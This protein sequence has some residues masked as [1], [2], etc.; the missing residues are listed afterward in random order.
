MKRHSFWAALLCAGLLGCTELSSG[1]SE[2]PSFDPT[3]TW[4]T[5][6]LP[7]T[8]VDVVLYLDIQGEEQ[9]ESSFV[10]GQWQSGGDP[11]FA[12]GSTGG[13][14]GT[15][16]GS[17]ITLFLKQETLGM[18]TQVRADLDGFVGAAPPATLSGLYT[19]LQNDNFPECV[20]QQSSVLLYCAEG[21]GNPCGN[22]YP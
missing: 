17:R 15:M 16:S 8:Q 10:S 20:G 12:A 22:L 21:P 4:A 11:C 1:S 7:G 13:Y 19:V 2:P 14:S 3:G 6:I 9:P 18:V 5:Q